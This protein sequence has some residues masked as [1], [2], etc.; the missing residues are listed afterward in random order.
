MEKYSALIV[1]DVKETSDYIYRRVSLL[2]PSIAEIDQAL[3]LSE[4][5]NLIENNSYDILFLDIQMQTGTGFDLLKRLSDKGEINFEIIFIT[6]ESDKEH[7]LRAIKFSA[8]DFLYKPL[9]DSELVVAV[10]RAL[11]K[12][13]KQELNHQVKLLLQQIDEHFAAK[14]DK[15]AFH[16][17]SGILQ[18]IPVDELK[19]IEADGVVSKV[20]LQSGET[21]KVNRNLGYYKDL[22][23]LEYNFVS[24]S[25]SI[26]LNRDYI[27]RYNHQTLKV[28]LTDD[29]ELPVSRRRAKELKEL[30]SERKGLSA[31]ISPFI[32][33]YGENKKR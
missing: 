5:E 20:Y 33:R 7:V 18:M 4:A 14:P 6:G 9:D 29:T 30:L 23:L 25:N 13:K 24:L 17:H 12:R 22:L 2:C 16:L 32:S 27:K 8:I 11:E 19:Y 10:N 21:I 28:T 3:T 15:I 1:E 26:L 31:I